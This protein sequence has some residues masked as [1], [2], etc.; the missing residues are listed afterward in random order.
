MNSRIFILFFSL[1]TSSLPI[2]SQIG[3][4]MDLKIKRNEF[5]TVNEEGFREAWK[6]VKLGNKYFEE[7]IGTF[8]LARDHYLIAHQYN[9]ENPVLNYRIGLC[10]LYTDDKYEALSYMR[11]AYNEAPDLHP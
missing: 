3:P 2:F 1:L 7:G 8:S 4:S 9:S 6:N 11:K 5:K 10:Y